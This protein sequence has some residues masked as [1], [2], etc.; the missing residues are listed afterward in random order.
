MAHSYHSQ[1]KINSFKSSFFMKMAEFEEISVTAL[2]NTSC[3]R[4]Y[5][6]IFSFWMHAWHF[7]TMRV[8]GTPGACVYQTD[9]LKTWTNH[10]SLEKVP[11]FWTCTWSY[12]RCSFLLLLYLQLLLFLLSLL[13][14]L[15]LLAGPTLFLTPSPVSSPTPVSSS[16]LHSGHVGHSPFDYTNMMKFLLIDTNLIF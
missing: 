14:W 2:E 10:I 7:L 6:M 11:S 13:S 3:Q 12:A 16:L 4:N 8:R 9:I 5:V 1:N 15:L